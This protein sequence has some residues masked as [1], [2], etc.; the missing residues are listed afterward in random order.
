MTATGP[1]ARERAL[2]HLG[3]SE[4]DWG[5]LGLWPAGDRSPPDY[6]GA[7][8]ALARRV[9]EA[10]GLRPGG[11]VLALGCGAGEE[12]RLWNRA[13]G[14]PGGLAIESD[15]AAAAAAAGVGG[16]AV[17]VGHAVTALEALPASECGRFD[18]VVCVDAAYH[19]V[20]RG[21][22]LV[23]ARRA[24]RPGGRIAFTDLVLGAA[25]SPWR[26]AVLRAA[27]SLAGVALREIVPT[28]GAVDRLRRAGFDV[29]T[30][31]RLDDEVLGGFAR[32]VARQTV[33][34]GRDARTAAWRRPRWTARLI[35]PCRAAGLGYALLAAT[36]A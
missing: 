25:T 11:R 19:F 18:A 21:R 34:L 1:R 16:W 10:A 24:L 4:A 8:E 35:P 17:H 22:L 5:N 32:H 20:P 29:V 23:A 14:V 12:L 13:F 27:G 36:A 2:L 7:C 30:V 31:E 3:G 26:G 9:G 28:S 15:A 33:R 6:A